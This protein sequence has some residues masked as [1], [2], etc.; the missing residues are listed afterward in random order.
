MS[1]RDIRVIV[2]ALF[3]I[4]GAGLLIMRDDTPKRNEDSGST[5]SPIQP[6]E[7]QKV[8][9]PKGD[10]ITVTGKVG[11]LKHKGNGDVQTLECAI[12][13]TTDD[14]KSYA[15]SSEDP[16]TTGSIPTDQKVRVTGTF[17]QQSSKYD[18]EGIIYVTSIE[19]L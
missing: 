11:C 16:M 9:P 3:F 2:F 7:P 17:T 12:G 5:A 13:M 15:L 10:P 19:K 8:T 14:S 1:M 4:V 18:S 6:S